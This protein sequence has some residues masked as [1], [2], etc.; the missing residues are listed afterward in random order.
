MCHPELTKVILNLFQDL[1]ISPKSYPPEKADFI[2]N[3]YTMQPTY[4]TQVFSNLENNIPPKSRSYVINEYFRNYLP[5]LYILYPEVV[6]LFIDGSLEYSDMLDIFTKIIPS[7]IK[8]QVAR[9]YEFRKDDERRYGTRS[10]APT[11]ISLT[12]VPLERE[13]DRFREAFGPR[14]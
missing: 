5:S 9:I 11:P 8:R 3:L 2:F 6:N 12:R 7:Q 13:I 10:F 4:Y 14:K 1:R